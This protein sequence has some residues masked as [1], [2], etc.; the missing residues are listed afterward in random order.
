MHE[1][2]AGHAVIGHDVDQFSS[3]SR[4]KHD[5][6]LADGQLHSLVLLVVL[7]QQRQVSVQAG[8]V[9]VALLLGAL[10]GVD[11]PFQAFRRQNGGHPGIAGAE[12]LDVVIGGADLGG[13]GGA[14]GKN[15]AQFDIIA[16]QPFCQRVEIRQAFFIGQ[17]RQSRVIGTF[18]KHIVFIN[19]EGGV[20]AE[21]L[22]VRKHFFQRIQTLFHTR[23]VSRVNDHAV[24]DFFATIEG[25]EI[26][27]NQ[28]LV[29]IQ[30]DG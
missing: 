27:R 30:R 26:E 21:R 6:V 29:G 10:L 20:V 18:I 8:G 17:S 15:A 9:E 23:K 19:R 12:K 1:C 16:F 22:G 2:A 7:Y 5:V 13:G 11:F 4:T 28:V 25:N 14:V 3:G 24:A